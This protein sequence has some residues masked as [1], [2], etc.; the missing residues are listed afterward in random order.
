VLFDNESQRSYVSD[1]VRAKLG[2]ASQSKERLKL[3]TIGE[4]RYKTQNCEV[5]ELSLK[6]WVLIKLSLSMLSVSPSGVHPCLEESTS[7]VH[8]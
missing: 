6:S 1:N 7:T 3:N 4:S 2:L 5:V 8:I